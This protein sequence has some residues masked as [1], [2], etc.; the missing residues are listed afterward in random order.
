TYKNIKDFKWDVANW[1]KG[2]KGRVVEMEPD[3]YSIFKG[4]K[5]PD[6]AWDFLKFVI[7]EPGGTLRQATYGTIPAIKQVAFSDAYLKSKG[8][9]QHVRLPLDD[10]LRSGRSNDFGQGWIE[11][12]SKSTDALQEAWLGKKSIEQAAKDADDA[13]T[14]VLKQQGNALF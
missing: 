12:T 10:A 4:S 3:G 2:P 9:P 5:N 14:K 13:I 7:Y 8:F 11:W 1:P 6:A